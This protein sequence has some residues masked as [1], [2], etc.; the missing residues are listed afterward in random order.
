MSWRR[1]SNRS[2]R[3]A[4]PSGPSNTYSFSTASHGIRRRLAASA[5]RARVNSFSFT[6]S[7]W[8]AAS[9]SGGDT[10]LE[11]FISLAS[12]TRSISFT[13]ILLSFDLVCFFLSAKLAHHKSGQSAARRRAGS[14][15]SRIRQA[16]R[17]HRVSSFLSCRF[18]YASSPNTRPGDRAILPKTCDILPPTARPVSAAW[19][20]T[21]FRARAHSGDAGAA[22][23]FPARANVLRQPATTSHVAAPDG[24]RIYRRVQDAPGCA[25]ASDRRGR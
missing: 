23:L 6:S 5:S 12:V 20:P 10:I 9:H 14:D 24:S 25:G 22:L 1:P 17:T 15:Q 3:L 11:R 13:F 18:A 2:S 19:L 4:L 21:L 16:D 7:C 8:R